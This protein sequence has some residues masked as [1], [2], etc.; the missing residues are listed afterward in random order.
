MVWS[1]LAG[2]YG[3]ALARKFGDEPPEEW[4][5]AITALSD[6]QLTQGMRRLLF[7]GKSHV[8]AL[9]EFVRLC[10]AIGHMDDVPDQRPSLP[11]LTHDKPEPD[12]WVV[13]GNRRLLRYITTRCAASSRCF[14]DPSRESNPNFVHNVKTLVAY[15]N[16][17]TEV[18]QETATEQGVP[19]DD[20]MMFWRECMREAESLFRKD[21]V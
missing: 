14:G 10:R 21:Q 5:A 17:W 6:Y 18:M 12:K 8:P 16:R 2:C 11:A 19:V 13:A 3:E 15:K 20:Q 7:S 9:P 1:R 4:R